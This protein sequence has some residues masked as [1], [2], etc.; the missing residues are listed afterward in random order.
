MH[1]HFWHWAP[2]HRSVHFVGRP[3][4]ASRDC[5]CAGP[6]SGGGSARLV[7]S[8]LNFR[9]A[10]DLSA[11]GGASRCAEH[12]H[13]RDIR[14]APPA[15]GFFCVRVRRLCAARA[16]T[17]ACARLCGRMAAL[18][19]WLR[20]HHPGHRCRASVHRDRRQTRRPR[21]APRAP[22]WRSARH[23][24]A[25][26]AHEAQRAYFRSPSIPPWQNLRACTCCAR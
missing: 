9:G 15:P 1:L 21:R 7:E 24:R 16:L 14:R 6:I 12:A 8:L 3:L 17:A 18:A 26:A 2:V 20:H 23:G 4:T 22:H 5:V 19:R 25:P 13:R 10:F 11:L